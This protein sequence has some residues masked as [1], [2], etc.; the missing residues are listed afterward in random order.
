VLSRG[1]APGFMIIG[2]DHHLPLMDVQIPWGNSGVA[3]FHCGKL[4]AITRL[5]PGELDGKH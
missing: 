2:D 3:P 5:P 1:A 4:T